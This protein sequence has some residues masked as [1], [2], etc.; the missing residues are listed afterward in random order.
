[1]RVLVVGYGSIGSRHARLLEEQG[2]DVHCVTRNND[3]P[4]PTHAG[5]EQG[6]AAVTP[7]CA[8]VCNETAA[9]R[10][11][12]ATLLDSGFSGPILMEK[13]LFQAVPDPVPQVADTVFTAYNLRFHPLLGRVRE[14]IKGVPLHSARLHVG[15]YLPDWR[16]GTD[17]AAGYSASRA[18]GGGVLRDLSHELDLA[19]WLL[20][21]WQR[22]TALGGHF[23]D[24]SIDS[25]DVYAVLMETEN[26]PAVSVNLN[27]LSKPARRGIEINGQGLS[28]KADLIAGTLEINGE[29][30]RFPI[31]R[32]TTYAT[33]LADFCSGERG[34]LC[35]Y[36]E[37]LDVLRLIEAAERANETRTWVENA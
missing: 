22:V 10:T 32:D 11:A 25:D 14:R 30:E 4:F 20:G 33:Q 3:C 8:V 35:T 18:K 17:Y 23:S 5:I 36:A 29:E 2:H 21:P 13:P 15:Q 7:D 12:L 27:Y 34:T 6:L 1:M 9:H 37:G 26:C 28:L 24:L 31:G 19:L 16:P